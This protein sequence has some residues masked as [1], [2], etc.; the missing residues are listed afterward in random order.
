MT[1]VLPTVKVKMKG[2][3]SKEVFTINMTDFNEKKHEIV[4]A[5]ELPP[6]KPLDPANKETLFG[7]SKQPDSWKLPDGS[8]LELST[9]VSEAHNRSGLTMKQWNALP[10]DERE[11]L[12]S[13]IVAEMVPT[14]VP[15][16][17]AKRGRGTA[18]KYFIIGSDGNQIGQ[19]EFA[20]EADA[21]AKL[22]ELTKAA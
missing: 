7:S 4:N 1:D 15:V 21:Q 16:K 3:K 20:T 9:V 5:E 19:E 13:E 14:P 12:I 8:T 17:I 22:D 2:D 11:S 10:Q 6:L 18:I